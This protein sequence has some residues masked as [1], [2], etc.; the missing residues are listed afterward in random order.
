MSYNLYQGH[1]KVVPSFFFF[2]NPRCLSSLIN[3]A[4]N[5]LLLT[6]IYFSTNVYNL[7]YIITQ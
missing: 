7:H 4:Y 5:N 2:L 6:L 3:L 1:L